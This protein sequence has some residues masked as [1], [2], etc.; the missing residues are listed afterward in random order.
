MKRKIALIIESVKIG[1]DCLFASLCFIKIFHSVAVL[2]GIGENGETYTSRT[3]YYYSI[4]YKLSR[5]GYD[6][7]FWL[8]LTVIIASAVISVLSIIFKNKKILT[9]VSHI[10]FGLAVAFFLAVL[11][12]ASSIRYC[13]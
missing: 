9:A 8:A 6:F 10:V 2:P 7:L 3:D 5:E 4:F 1:I 11:F 13:Y 12:I